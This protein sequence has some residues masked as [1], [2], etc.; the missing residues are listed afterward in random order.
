M[1]I[2]D[3]FR[4]RHSCD[5][6]AMDSSTS[7]VGWAYWLGPSPVHRCRA[8]TLLFHSCRC[9][10]CNSL[11]SPRSVQR[12]NRLGAFVF[13]RRRMATDRRASDCRRR[14]APTDR[15]AASHEVLTV[16]F[17]VFRPRRT[18]QSEPC[19]GLSRFGVL[20]FFGTHADLASPL[21]F[22]CLAFPVCYII[23]LETPLGWNIRG[24]RFFQPRTRSNS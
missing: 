3:L 12:L 18:A 2:T 24:L 14:F 21:R 5:S 23:S 1:I 17:S 20:R 9:V 15:Q 8:G 7:M 11:F 6:L 13:L 10:R 19:P 16:P 4:L 22:S